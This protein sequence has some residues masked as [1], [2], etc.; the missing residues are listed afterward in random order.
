MSES[1][2]SSRRILVIS[3][4]A[5]ICELLQ[6]ALTREGYEVVCISA[7]ADATVV[8]GILFDLVITNTRAPYSSGQDVV[9]EIHQVLG[10]VPVLHLDDLT[11]PLIAAL[12]GHV[13][14]LRIPFS[15]AAL[16]T[17]VESLLQS[18]TS[19]PERTA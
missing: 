5:A 3:D 14:S 4:Y 15:I 18:D 11:R 19:D 10:G 7:I 17:A 8:E 16:L 6:L 13:P 1:P 12:P 2:G 9:R